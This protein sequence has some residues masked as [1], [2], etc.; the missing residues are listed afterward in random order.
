MIVDEEKFTCLIHYGII[1]DPYECISCKNNFCHKCINNVLKTQ[2]KC[3]LCVAS[4]FLYREN[5]SLKRILQ[6]IKFI[7]QNCGKSFKNEDEY[8]SHTENCKIEK[9]ICIICENEF[10]ENN[11]YEH[12]IKS[13]KSDIISLMN[14]NSM[15]NKINNKYN[16]ND[17]FINQKKINL[18]ISIFNHQNTEEYKKN[19]NNKLKRN[20]DNNNLIENTSSINKANLHIKRLP[21]QNINIEN[22]SLNNYDYPNFNELK[23]FENQNKNNEQ[24]PRPILN[25][26]NYFYNK[27][28]SNKSHRV[29]TVSNQ[30]VNS[31]YNM[32]LNT[33]RIISN[34]APTYQ[35]TK[36]D[37]NIK[38]CYKENKTIP[39]SCCKDHICRPG[40]CLCKKCMFQNIKEMKLKKG[41]LINKKGNVC[42]FERNTFYC[43]Q[44]YEKIVINVKKNVFKNK[45]KCGI[46]C[47]CP[48]CEILTKLKNYYLNN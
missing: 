28:S 40:N 13:H 12:I 39:C 42:N 3:P 6:D 26:I 23:Q 15:I 46:Y 25:D 33:E 10:N 45:I 37:N 29:M 35:E 2:N 41:Q 30:N 9:Y 34:S 48:E 32:N 43:D 19:L 21:L 16:S 36:N 38:F 5:I 22:E 4:P 17:E 44:I 20:I 47:P 18:K 1:D 8:N 11:F 7:C 14:Q 27:D 31:F 24:K